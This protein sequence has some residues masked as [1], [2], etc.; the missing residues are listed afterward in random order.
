[1]CTP[2]WLLLSLP[3]FTTLETWTHAENARLVRSCFG[4]PKGEPKVGAWPDM[5]QRFLEVRLVQTSPNDLDK[6][7]EKQNAN[8]SMK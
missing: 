2:S 3:P 1:M 8:L 6:T 5:A 4:S 7:Y